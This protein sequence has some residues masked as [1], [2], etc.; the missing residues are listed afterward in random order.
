MPDDEGGSEATSDEGRSGTER[1]GDAE[2]RP[3]LSGRD[4]LR[5]I[6]ASY[7]AS[8]PYFLVVLLGLALA[9]WILT[10]LVF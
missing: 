7:A 1:P 3:D 4:I 9:T 2:D 6:R 10:T 5:L 8:L